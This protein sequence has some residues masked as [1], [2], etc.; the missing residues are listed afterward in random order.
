MS[1]IKICSKCNRIRLDQYDF[2]IRW[3]NRISKYYYRPECQECE[4][5]YYQNNKEH[6][7]QWREDNSEYLKEYVKQ[8]RE[9]YKEYYQEHYKKYYQNNKKYII[10]KTKKWV[11]NNKKY[12]KEY[13]RQWQENNKDKVNVNNSKR[14]A[15][16]LN[17]T[18]LNANMFKIL[19][20]YSI[21]SLMNEISINIKWHVDHIKP[22]SRGGLHH[23]DNLQV[24]EASVNLRKSNK[25]TK[26]NF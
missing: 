17:Q 1:N 25:L 12:R 9:D 20:I 24:L 19:E 5:Q 26:E 21:T 13:Y 18:P 23:Q 6:Y 8:R 4:K 7:K 16:K 2:S 11:K 3:D 14:R 10:E 15:M 22:L